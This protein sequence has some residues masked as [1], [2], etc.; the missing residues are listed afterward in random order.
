MRAVLFVLLLAGCRDGSK[1]LPDGGFDPTHPLVLCSDQPCGNG[2]SC[3][4]GSQCVSRPCD[5]GD[6]AGFCFSGTGRL[7]GQC[8]PNGCCSFSCNGIAAF[9]CPS[10][11]RCVSSPECCDRAG[12]CTR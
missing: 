4:A 7:N 2:Q 10:A 11:M 8:D 5:G 6:C 3:P 12:S 1:V 9:E